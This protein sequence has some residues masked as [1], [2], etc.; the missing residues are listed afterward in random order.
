MSDRIEVDVIHM[1]GV[2]LLVADGV[3]PIAALPDAGFTFAHEGGGPVFGVRDLAGEQRL[4]HLPS[5]GEIVV[6]GRQGPEAMHVVRE[7]DPGADVERVTGSR[8][9]DGVAEGVDVSD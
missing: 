9:S 7:D 1:R 3:F 6:A 5:G 4:D 2:I 8:G